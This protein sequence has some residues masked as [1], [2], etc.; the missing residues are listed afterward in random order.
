LKEKKDFDILRLINLKIL[1]LCGS[2]RA[3]ATEYVLREALRM[4][5]EEGFETEFFTVRGKKI[6][7]CIHCDHCLKKGGCIIQD[8]MQKLYPKLE[9]ADGIIISSPVYN[10]GVSAQTKAVMDRTRALLAADPDVLRGKP[11]AAVAVGGDRIGGQELAIQQIITFYV[12]N[13]VLTVSGGFFGANIGAAFWSKDTMDGIMG[14]E[15]G[16]R[17]L[18]KTV[19]RLSS[20]LKNRE[21][22]AKK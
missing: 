9:E 4:L 11:G 1:G 2:P 16:F 20:F 8:D 6:G 21:A 18:R 7:F 12:L 22:Y 10:G 19:K 5:E 3:K 17:S 13:G 14:D 15:E